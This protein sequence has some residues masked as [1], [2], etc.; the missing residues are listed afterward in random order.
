MPSPFGFLQ[1]LNAVRA[2]KSDPKENAR[3]WLEPEFVPRFNWLVRSSGGP[4]RM[5]R[6]NEIRVK[7]QQ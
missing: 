1:F 2:A 5:D 3:H 4:T 7:L 6:M